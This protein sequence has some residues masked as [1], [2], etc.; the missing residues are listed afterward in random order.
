MYIAAT[1]RGMLVLNSYRAANDFLEVNVGAHS[2]AIILV[3]SVSAGVTVIMRR[4][5][6]EAFNA[7]SC[8]VEFYP[9]QAKEAVLLTGG[10]L[11]NDRGWDAE[12]RRCVY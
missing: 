7:M 8:D 10:L 9:T 11:R 1:G 5:G 2:T 3:Q 12:I 6:H 4:A